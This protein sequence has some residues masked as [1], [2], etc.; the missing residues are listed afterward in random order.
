MKKILF[1]LSFILITTVSFGQ[2]SQVKTRWLKT[3]TSSYLVAG[4]DSVVF[5]L[6]PNWGY[7]LQIRPVLATGCDSIYVSV[8]GYISNSDGDAAWTPIA[9]INDTYTAVAD[10][11]VTANAT[12]NGAWMTYTTTFQNV[13]VKFVFLCLDNTNEDNVLRVYLVAKPN[14]TWTNR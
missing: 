10:T 14:Y 8:K 1:L 6:Q 5:P 13:R 7:A 2:D 11:L 12:L 4:S 9:D 3:L